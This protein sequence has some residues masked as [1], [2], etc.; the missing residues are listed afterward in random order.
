MTDFL[1]LGYTAIDRGDFQ[2]AVN[3]FMRALEQGKSARCYVGLGIAYASLGDKPTARWAI[4]KALDLEPENKQANEW[5][6]RLPRQVVRPAAVVRREVRFR[7]GEHH[8]EISEKGRWRRFFV[9]GVNLGLGLPG[10]FPGE[11]PIRKGTYLKWFRQMAEL[12]ANSLRVYTV[13]PPAFYEALAE[14]NSGGGR[15]FLFQGVWLELPE[16]GDFHDPAYVQYLHGNLREAVDAVLGRT[17]LPERPGYAHGI[18]DCDVSP[19]TA[20]FIIGREWES[21]AVKAYNERH[22]RKDGDFAGRFVEARNA[23]PFEQWTAEVC[24]YLQGYE[25]KTYGC[26]H[27]VTITCW[28]TLDPLEHPS[29]SRYEDGLAWQGHEVDRSGCNENEDVEVLDLAKLRSRGGAG[30]FAMYHV[31]PYYPDFMNNDFLDARNPYQAYLDK[32]TRHHGTQ[33]VL[34][35]EFGVPSSREVTHWQRVGWHHGGHDD[36]A[37]G[38]INGAQMEAIHQAGCAGGLLFSWSDE[39]FKRNWVFYPYE[40]P[41]ERNPLWFNLQDAEQ[42]YGLLAAYP[43]YPSMRTTLS[44]KREEWGDATLLYEKKQSLPAFRFNDGHDG[45]RAMTRVMAN[46]DEGFLYLMLEAAG[47]V[48]FERANYLFG[49]ST[50]NGAGETFL[51]FWTNVTSPVGL[52]FLVHLAGKERSRILVCRSY[53]KYLNADKGTIVPQDTGQGEWVVMQNITNHRRISKDQSRFYPSRV[54]S[55][56]GLRHGSLD[57]RNPDYTSLADF[58]VTGSMIEI[59]IPWGLLNVTDPSSRQVI[60]FDKKGRTRETKGI[61]VVAYSFAPSG[62]GLKA[63][64]TGM[65]SNITD[66]FPA[67]SAASAV[68]HYRWE[69]WQHPT[70]HTFLK[71]SYYIYRDVLARIPE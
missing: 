12:G 35:A 34:I 16:N 17:N 2:E 8:L 24:D 40:L 46:H 59:R 10:Y 13:H 64:A 53:D 66:S 68:S 38:R 7:V 28:P 49:L 23:S 21:C 43:G 4:A 1:S 67:R 27:P 36:E 54:F 25:H 32:L 50:C 26:T 5:I 41:A 3:L 9:K 22:G 57:P 45:A 37:Q 19:W 62:K 48:D 30:F 11:Y 65:K 29:E 69:G 71:K 31:Y 58:R 39:W 61:G 63:R 55:M 15:L 56:S 42:N 14:F 18:Y 6:E 47:E 44:G 51:P 33:P 60:W 70:Y 20:G 52:T